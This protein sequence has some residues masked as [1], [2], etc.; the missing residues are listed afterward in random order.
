MLQ[1]NIGSPDT[2]RVDQTANLTETLEMHE[3]FEPADLTSDEEGDI[4]IF[5]NGAKRIH[6]LD[7]EF[8]HQVAFGR[9][10]PGPGEF[11]RDVSELLFSPVGELVALEKWNRTVHFYSLDGEFLESFFLQKDVEVSGTPEAG[12]GFGIPLGMAVDRDGNLYFTDR[13]W[14]YSDDQ[15]QVFSRE[16]EFLDSHLPQENFISY[17]EARGKYN[18]MKREQEYTAELMNERQKRIAV[19]LKNNVVIGHRGAYVIEKYTSNFELQ[20][21]RKKEFKPVK[22]PHARRIVHRGEEGYSSGMGEGAVAD[23]EVDDQNRIF[24]SIGC[25]DGSIEDEELDQLSHWIDVFDEDGTHLARLLEDDLPPLPIR[26]GYKI[27][28]HESRLLVLGET[29]LWVYNIVSDS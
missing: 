11:E 24:V 6:V 21:R 19:D 13:V 20:W 27:D 14:Y 23:L 16:G 18:S 8:D 29:Q 22:P 5:D 3:I 7:D 12:R 15:I 26:R 2:V 9:E 25:Y 4:Y 10:G 1:V 28:V 17:T